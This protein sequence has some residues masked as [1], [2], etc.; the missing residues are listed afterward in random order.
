MAQGSAS[1]IAGSRQV[2]PRRKRKQT[3]SDERRKVRRAVAQAKQ[4]ADEIQSASRKRRTSR[5][6]G[7][8]NRAVSL[9]SELDGLYGEFRADRRGIYGA[10]VREGGDF[11][12][13]AGSVPVDRPGKGGGIAR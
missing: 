7:E 12:R 10:G 9:D 8:A 4:T 3:P 1:H 5:A 11:R 2:E 13:G 6:A